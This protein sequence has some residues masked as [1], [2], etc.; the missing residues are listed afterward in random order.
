[1]SWWKEAL[2][3]VGKKALE[4]AAEEIGKKAAKK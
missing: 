4:M 1:M 2:K 3:W